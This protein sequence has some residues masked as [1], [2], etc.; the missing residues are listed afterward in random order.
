MRSLKL[1]IPETGTEPWSPLLLSQRCPVAME[2]SSGAV[3]GYKVKYP[4]SPT[5][6]PLCRSS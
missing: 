2:A 4:P 3:R 6:T 1:H 5:A